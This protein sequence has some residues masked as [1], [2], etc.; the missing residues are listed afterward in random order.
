MNAKALAGVAVLGAAALLAFVL[1]RS[2]G[3]PALPVAPGQEATPSGAQGRPGGATA[4]PAS[5]ALLGTRPPPDPAPQASSANETSSRYV[6]EAIEAVLGLARES[7]AAEAADDDA[8]R[9]GV[10][11]RLQAARTALIELL[12]KN[13]AAAQG[14]L[15]QL[16]VSDAVDAAALARVLR[17]V[18]DEALG[19]RL[20]EAARDAEAAHLREA[21]LLALEGREVGLWRAPVMDAF[22]ADPDGA[23]RDRAAQVLSHALA[24]PRLMA[25]R[26]ALRAP[27][28]AGLASPDAEQRR[29]SIQALALD[30]DAPDEVLETLR[31]LAA[32]DPDTSI[33][34]AASMALRAI[35]R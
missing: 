8:A 34:R 2:E 31:D 33:R 7:A 16:L 1:L 13:G 22:T 12:R 24:D 6:D 23:V 9:D 10:R 11:E 19:R 18:R 3:D 25:E 4:A 21:A 5:Q 26:E 27:L 20:A 28:R 35:E 32:S 29:R 14:V 17:F 30:R 15:D